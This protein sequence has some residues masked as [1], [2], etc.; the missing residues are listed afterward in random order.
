[1]V[2]KIYTFGMEPGVHKTLKQLA[3]KWGLSMSVVLEALI[4]EK[5]GAPILEKPEKGLVEEA[6]KKKV[7]KTEEWEQRKCPSCKK[8]VAPVATCMECGFTI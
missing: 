2:K 3:Q 4:V 5:V 7:A 6:I 1:M 8:M